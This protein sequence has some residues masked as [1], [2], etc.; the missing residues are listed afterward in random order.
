[1][2]KVTFSEKLLT[3]L[4]SIFPYNVLLHLVEEI[5]DLRA[6]SLRAPA[7]IFMIKRVLVNDSITRQ[8]VS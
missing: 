7:I 5:T 2:D 1:M 4:F 8:K 3:L 6:L